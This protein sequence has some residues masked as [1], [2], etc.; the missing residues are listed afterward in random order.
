MPILTG[1]GSPTRTTIA[2]AHEAQRLG[3]QGLLLLPHYL[4]EAS[5][6]GLIE[7]VAEVCKS[8]SI[9][10]V[11]YNLA[12]CR[13]TPDSLEKLAARCTNLI[14]FKDGISDIELMV[15]IWGRLGDRFSDLGDL[16]TAAIFASAY[17]AIGT[18]VYS[19]VIFNFVPKLTMDFYHATAADNFATTN[20][21][22]DEFLLHSLDI[23][24]RKAGYSV[25][26]VKAGARLVGYSSGPVRA[27]LTNFTAEEDDM[28]LKLIRAQGSQKAQK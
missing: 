12:N 23:R 6:D 20:R 26:I 15:S 8:V 24:N 4:T 11:V 13:L 22:I 16:P 7:Q 3:A 14:D 10:V 5:Q 1:M 9:D 21:L 25:S 27:L 28:L 17:K 2:L 18:P 19:S